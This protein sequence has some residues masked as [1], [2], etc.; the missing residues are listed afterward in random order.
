MNG[1][2]T[3]S[4]LVCTWCTRTR[5]QVINS[6]PHPQIAKTSTHC[7]EEPH[8]LPSFVRIRL[9]NRSSW[10][11]R[12]LNLQG[13]R[14]DG[15]SKSMLTYAYHAMHFVLPV[16]PFPSST[17]HESAFTRYYCL[18]KS[19]GCTLLWSFPRSPFHLC[20]SSY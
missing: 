5:D 3:N 6:L 8:N 9:A 19:V 13:D 2:C 1:E 15:K 11:N 12:F 18:P 17:V 16:I 7:Q 4:T 14:I 20:S 10:L